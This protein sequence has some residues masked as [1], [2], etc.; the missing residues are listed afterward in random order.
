[1][2]NTFPVELSPTLPQKKVAG[3][4]YLLVLLLVIFTPYEDFILKFIPGPDSIYFYSRFI[5]E[6]LIYSIFSLVMI[7]RIV[8][9]KPF[10]G[11]PLDLPIFLFFVV[12]LL[13]ALVNGIPLV[14]CLINMRPLIRYI[15]LYYLAVNMDLTSE[16]SRT[17][18]RAAIIAGVVELGVGILQYVSRGLL[19][20]ILLPRATDIEVGGMTK[21]FVLLYGREIGSIYGT[22]GDTV[23]FGVY[24]V[25]VF[26]LVLAEFHIGA[27][28]FFKGTDQPDTKAKQTR[29]NIAYALMLL[30][31][32]AIVLTYVRACFFAILII[33]TLHFSAS[34]SNLK[35]ALALVTLAV[36]MITTPIVLS[37]LSLRYQGN[38]RMTEQSAIDDILGVFTPAYVSQARTQRLGAIFG[39]GPV[40]IENKPLLGYGPDQLGAIEDINL[41][42]SEYLTKVWTEEGFKDVYWVAILTF[43]GLAGLFVIMWLFYRTYSAAQSLYKASDD[44]QIKQLSLIVMYVVVAT[45]FV[46]FFN[47]SLE[48]R[49]YGTYFW[50]LPGLLFGLANRPA[51]K[52]TLSVRATQGL[53]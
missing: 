24:M 40:V 15:A 27:T 31:A 39:V 50:L 23:L 37:Q 20:P 16:Q 48:F 6:L 25:L 18:I 11:T 51:A 47:R 36:L 53:K 26:I 5:R 14:K 1:M 34:L 28:G 10:Q 13:S 33:A 22:T 46:M 19:D 7:N 41:S 38:A 52:G 49:I 43:Y 21:A 3:I 8:S 4:P 17:I 45:S 9:R 32:F 30:I 44:R 12:A 35:K 2:K 42:R 29:R